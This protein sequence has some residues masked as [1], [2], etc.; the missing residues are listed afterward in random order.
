MTDP[1]IENLYTTIKELEA[2]L[3][4]IENDLQAKMRRGTRLKSDWVLPEEWEIWTV[5]VKP[6]SPL[7]SAGDVH[8]Q[9]ARFRDYWLSQPGSKGVK[10]DWFA[11]WKN[12][13]RNARPKNGQDRYID[14]SAVAK[15]ERANDAARQRE[16]G[17]RCN[18][19]G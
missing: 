15:V 1:V 16:A 2:R 9:A 5:A 17:D 7:L 3:T 12:W 14:N 10:A 6:N 13:I 11:T 8:E 19:N 18:G 4:R